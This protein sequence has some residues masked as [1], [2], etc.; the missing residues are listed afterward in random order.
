MK[1]LFARLARTAVVIAFGLVLITA[2]PAG[3]SESKSSTDVAVI[4]RV[5]GHSDPIGSVLSVT[6]SSSKGGIVIGAVR[7]SFTVTNIGRVPAMFLA[8]IVT[9]GPDPATFDLAS[10]SVVYLEAG[11]SKLF[12]YSFVP[13]ALRISSFNVQLAYPGQADSFMKPLSS[14]TT[15]ALR[16]GWLVGGIVSLIV[17]LAAWR[18]ATFEWRLRKLRI[19]YEMLAQSLG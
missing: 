14:A 12:S 1:V 19:R 6:S 7:G 5:S 4:A 3:A 15:Y 17:M 2:G 10:G 16:L 13:G 8:K 11:A 9:G 18:L